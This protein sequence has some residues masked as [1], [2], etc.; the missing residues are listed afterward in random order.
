MQEYTSEQKQ[1]LIKKAPKWAFNPYAASHSAYRHLAEPRDEKTQ[2]NFY[3]L[4]HINKASLLINT[5]EGLLDQKYAKPF[6]KGL[7]TVIDN[8]NHGGPRPQNIVEFEPY[9][10]AEAGPE[11]SRIH[12]GR[13]SQDMLTTTSMA[14][15]RQSLLDLL[16][17]V[18]QVMQ[19]LSRLAEENKLTIAP[20]YT[21]G[22]AAQPTSYGHYLHAFL[23][24]FGRDVERIRFYYQHVNRCAMGSMVLNGT[25][26]PLD[27]ERMA[28]YLGFDEIFYNCY[29]AT[30]VY[31]LEYSAEA[32]AV[33]NTIALH[34]SNFI[35]DVMQQYAQ[36]RPWILLQEGGKNTYVSSAMPQKRNPG[37]LNST[38]TK[39][40]S[41]IG[42]STSAVVRA[43]NVP[44]GMAD[45]R[46]TDLTLLVWETQD[47]LHD[48]NDILSALKVNPKRSLEELNLDWTASQEIADRLMR[49]DNVPFRIGHHVAS[50]I[51]GYARA[52]DIRPLDFPYEVAK[53]IYRDNV[54]QFNLP[55][56]PEEF[57]FDEEK[58]KDT[59][60][61]M[62][63]V[64]RRAVKGGPQLPELEK[65]LKAAQEEIAANQK[66]HDEQQQH[67]NEAIT[68]LDSDFAKLL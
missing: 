52:H 43:H 67:I 17:N 40:S 58:F 26:W 33:C 13:S 64:Q 44:P 18:T 25:G 27:R 62:Q 7:Q 28:K 16:Q 2:D 11:V 46:G 23:E 41:I 30:Q 29:D 4:A 32:A 21:N 49:E 34:V 66:W 12:A 39:A 48:F 63:I 37:I 57:P 9:W 42:D 47:L 36:P 55:E 45:A 6:A 68:K 19:H 22:V 51:V 35:A 20:A 14:I 3:W 38:R 61:P 59:L 5:S 8:A 15:M 54:K 10:I 56:V 65:M 24:A 31:T 53:K 1:A 60:N 50:D